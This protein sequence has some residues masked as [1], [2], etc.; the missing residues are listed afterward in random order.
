MD[1]LDTPIPKTS[2]PIWNTVLTYGGYCGGI[3]VAFS[4]LTYLID[5][6]V[7]TLSGLAILY[8]SI[9]I[10][11]FVFAALAMRHQRDKLEG[12]YIG[13]GK[14]L[15]IG[16]LTVF[17][18]MFISGIWNYVLVNFID[19]NVIVV[20]KEQFM[21]SW[22]QNMPQADLEKALEGFDKA[23][24]IGSTLKSTLSGGLFFGLFIGLIMAAFMKR[25]PEIST[26]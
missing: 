10:I 16:L 13:Y 21:E 11:G 26:R 19:P 7:M 9:L 5:F 14:A 8:S 22:G 2:V 6:N 1:N 18:G 24:E 15:L 3:L 25:S 23:G 20:M 17:I 12:G 4:I